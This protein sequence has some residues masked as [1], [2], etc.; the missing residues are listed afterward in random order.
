MRCPDCIRGPEGL[1]GH[2]HIFVLLHGNLLE[3]PVY[4]CMKCQCRYKRTHI[5][6]TFVWK[7]APDTAGWKSARA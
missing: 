7:T 2:D 1:L 3:P 4:A 6:G 5:N